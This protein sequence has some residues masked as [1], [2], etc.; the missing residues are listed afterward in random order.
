MSL[1]VKWQYMNLRF[2]PYNICLV[3]VG[4]MYCH[5]TLSAMN[6]LLCNIRYSKLHE[7]MIIC[8]K[9]DSSYTCR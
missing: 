5:M 4:F 2:G 1:Q 7:I 9:I 6:Y 8:D 3:T